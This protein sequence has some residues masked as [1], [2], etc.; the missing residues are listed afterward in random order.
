MPDT[1]EADWVDRDD[2]VKRGGSGKLPHS[3]RWLERSSRVGLATSVGV[4]AS[5]RASLAA[6]CCLAMLETMRAP[7]AKA[8]SI[9]VDL[10]V[11]TTP[12][13]STLT[14]SSTLKLVLLNRL[15]QDVAEYSVST[16]VDNLA[17]GELP[18]AG[19][20][21]VQAPAPPVN[22]QKAQQA[23]S[24]V[25]ANS[26]LR[27]ALDEKTAR[28]NAVQVRS[29]LLAA[30]S[31]TGSSCPPAVKDE[32]RALLGAMIS[33]QPLPEVR[34]G[35][36]LTIT[37]VRQPAGG[38][39]TAQ[40]WVL[41]FSAGQRGSWRTT[42]GFAFITNFLMP[43]DRYYTKDTLIVSGVDSTKGLVIS[44]GSRRPFDLR[45]VPSLFF[46]W[47]PRSRELSPLSLGATVGL[48]FDLTN[49]VVMAGC[50][51]TYNQNA[52][53][54][55]GL[56]A[57]SQ[58]RL[59]DKYSEGEIVTTSLDASQ[60]HHNVYVLNVYFAFALRLSSN[61]FSGKTGQTQ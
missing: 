9:V 22:P 54:S 24:L 10:A 28:D 47:L 2:A 59:L 39:G 27:H 32:A 43:E 49:P 19:L 33:E 5:L 13:T 31:D 23:C 34:Q 3:A 1:N 56:A 25:A 50:S 38:N 57:H 12:Y 42:F 46:E 35:Q 53:L 36:Q 40:T 41:T 6:L 55:F 61:P 14:A 44:H 11:Q 29:A 26:A 4:V 37:I 51:L 15:E 45:Y 16:Q 20:G 21:S 7:A 48:G 8:Q 18:T 17:L 58:Q 30:D 52:S 60:L